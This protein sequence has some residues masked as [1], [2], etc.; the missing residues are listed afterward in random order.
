[1][2]PEQIRLV[3]NN[4][5]SLI[6]VAQ[7]ASQLFYHK[8]FT[9]EPSIQ[10]L[11]TNDPQKQQQKFMQMLHNIVDQLHLIDFVVPI[12]HELGVRHLAYQVQ[13]HHHQLF[14]QTLVETI[15]ELQGNHFTP[16]LAQSWTLAYDTIAF[17]MEQGAQK[18]K[19]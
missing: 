4:F 1:M 6:P 2:T 19:E 17:Y 3:Q 10:D 11:F 12:M 9:L 16:E 14:K 15:S 18:H 8:L 5:K 7:Q 13:S